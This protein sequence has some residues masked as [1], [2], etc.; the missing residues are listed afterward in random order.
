MLYIKHLD[1]IN[2]HIVYTHR[3]HLVLSSTLAAWHS[4]CQH[5]LSRMQSCS[6]NSS[7]YHMS[8][9]EKSFSFPRFSH[10]KME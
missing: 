9:P 4:G 3:Q 6:P 10:L 1:H 8:D 5:P 7:F 2:W